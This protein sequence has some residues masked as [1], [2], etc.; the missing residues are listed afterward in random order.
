MFRGR[1]AA[2]FLVAGVIASDAGTLHVLRTTPASPADP[3]DVVT[4]T[5]DRP[6]A[7][8]LDETVDPNA[9]F[10]IAPEVAGTVEWR[11]PVTLRFTP[12]E[13]LT[14]GATYVVTVRSS[15]TAMDGSRLD[16]PFQYSFTVSPPRILDGT[17]AGPR[18]RPRYLDTVP[19]FSILLSAEPDVAELARHATIRLGATCG[20]GSVAL[21]P[22]GTPARRVDPDDDPY[23]F[24]YAGIR[25]WPAPDSTKDLRRVVDLVAAAP[26]PPDC[27]DTLLLPNVSTATQPSLRWPF[28]TRG[29]LRVSG[30]SCPGRACPTGPLRLQLSTPVLGA[31]L[32][33]H[34]R[35]GP[36]VPF[37][38]G[39]TSRASAVWP[40]LATLEPHHT[41]SVLVDGGLVD[42]FGQ[43]LGTPVFRSW[44]TSGYAPAV[45]YEYGSM[46]VEREG[47]GTLAVQHVNADTLVVSR[48]AV[49]DSL[50]PAFLSQRWGWGAPWSEARSLIREDTV[51]VPGAEDQRM[52]S[53]IRPEGGQ[54]S[55]APAATLWALQ[56]SSPSLDSLQRM[57]R[58]IALVQ[59]TD[60]A[61]TA[62][63]GVD[64]AAVWVTG[65][66]DGAARPGVTVVLHDYKGRPLA[67]GRTDESG[68]ATLHDF[69]TWDD[70]CQGWQCNSFEGYVSASLG[71]D[72]AVVPI[73]AYDPDLSP[74][75]FN[76]YSAWGERRA[77]VAAAV[78]TERGI[79]RPGERVFVKAIL[80]RGPLG[81]LVA[82]RGDSIRW[83]FHD[84]EQAV[85]FDTVTTLSAFGTSE[86]HVRLA[87]DLPLGTYRVEVQAQVA[88]SWQSVASDYYR[89]AEYRP[90]EFLVDVTGEQGA[91]FAGDSA[92]FHVSARYLFGAPMGH[93]P[94]S[95][96][97]RSQSVSPW[98][99]SIPGAED[100]QIGVAW[101]WWQDQSAPGVRVTESGVDSLDATGAWDAHRV[102]PRTADGRPTRVTFVATV[103]DA[104]RQIG[105]S[106]A[107]VLVHPA[108]FYIGARSRGAS[109]F[110]RAGD[111]VGI[112]VIAVTPDG[113]KLSGVP[114]EGTVVRREWHSTRLLRD[115]NVRET[116]SWV[117]D[118]V[119]TCSLRSA[120]EPV[121]C[122]FTPPEGGSYTVYFTAK[123]DAGRDVRTSLQRWASGKGWVPWNDES[124][125]K[126]DVIPDR[127][128]YSV[129]DTATV[130]FASPITDA[131]AWITVE[132]ERVLEQRRL[133][134][135]SGATTLK[136]PITE[137]YAPNV[138]VSIVVVR[139]RSAPP[140][141]LDDPGRPTLR[142]GYTQLRITPEVKRLTVDV[143]PL[144]PEYRPGDSASFALTV[145]DHGGVGRR[146]EVALWAVDE[147]VLALTGY[148]TPDPI[149]LLYPARGLGMRLA[150][151][152]VSVAPQVPEGQKGFRSPGG[153][154]G[155]DE[156]G[157]LRSRF[158]TTAFFLGSVVTDSTGRAT[159]G[160][161]LPD[162]LT[163]F[164]VMAVAVTE[165]DRY[166]SGSSEFLV[167]RPLL[168]RPALPRFVREGDRFSA[169]V[170]VNSRMG[171]TPEVD[172]RARTRGI[173]L[174][175]DDHE[176]QRLAAG[177]G[178]DVR[179]DFEAQAGDSAHFRFDASSGKEADAVAVAVPIRPN[180]YPLSNTV[181]GVVRD[182]ATAAFD[183]QDDVDPKRSRVEIRVGS[184]VLTAVQAAR[185][186]LRLY[187]YQCTEQV[188][189]AALPLV[190]LLRAQALYPD[191]R[192]APAD[193][194]RQV[195]RAVRVLASRQRADGGIGYWSYTDWTSP[196]LSAYAGR[197]LLE[198][199]EAGVAVPDTVLSSLRGYMSRALHD[200]GRIV[201]R[202]AVADFWFGDPGAVLAEQVAAVDFLSRAGQPDIPVENTLVGQAQ[203]LRWEDRVLLGEVLA[204]RGQT[205]VARLLVT[206]AA[207]QVRVEG[208][209]AV[210]PDSAGLRL[211]FMS[212]GRAAAR[213]LDA[214]LA[215]DPQSPLLGPLVETLVDQ[216]RVDLAR[217]R[218]WF[219]NTQDYGSTVLALVHF[220][221]LRRGEPP[222]TVRVRVGDRTLLVSDGATHESRD[223]TLSLE[224]LVQR[225][226][227]GE[228]PRTTLSVEANGGAPA[229]F[230]ITVREAPEGVQPT[231]VER[232]IQVDR[233]Y[234]S[235]TTGKPI[236]TAQ[237]GDVV[238]VR[239]R[240]RVPSIRTFVVLADP[241][242]AG[243][244]PV[245]LSLR[246]LSAFGATVP[247]PAE[248]EQ[249]TGWY[250]GSWDSGVW[251]VFDH[252]ELRDDRVVYSSTVLWPGTYTATY[253]ARA[254]ATGTFYYPPAHA[255][256]MYN[257]GVNGR[258]GGGKFTVTVP[259]R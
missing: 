75:H 109:Y 211:Y 105:S 166:G 21:R 62:R 41:Y 202:S 222:T 259:G 36:N 224:G 103:T 69:R 139:G 6:V 58:P 256:E 121:S 55:G 155:A 150:S 217:S 238:R 76:V 59:V 198:A 210:L 151:N 7:G 246:T 160:A 31:E 239:L 80:R 28:W 240:V 212:R 223:T 42:V 248:M 78:F 154:G 127:D 102:L 18:V 20:G 24:R 57:N 83:L 137:A 119:A 125:F 227:D 131:E 233:W 190:A 116:G 27:S 1:V 177:R 176:R 252:K 50:E 52:F 34:V 71:D 250:Y 237:E 148:R 172:V 184:S 29:P 32:L 93:A 22:A 136:F 39:D 242:P 70:P 12:S 229:Y 124:K 82:P 68:L 245:D 173:Q 3:Y 231:P 194:R 214:L 167:T 61:V 220:E 195:E 107:S 180:Y 13:P 74:W 141:P 157:I 81:K 226:R 182:T 138:F 89:V 179:F 4:V 205:A 85:L 114:V 230:S 158:Q 64:E 60:L 159:V 247:P 56:V 178:A 100:Y 236:V 209:K 104:N 188:S 77:P 152:L 221:R 228:P 63:V 15:F 108:A 44:T 253:L 84:R 164:R 225:G 193:A 14:P 128:R 169:G 129:G 135:T 17:P 72:R 88:G 122:D 216:G 25:R 189:S 54:G 163:T 43:R 197:V 90:P 143:K 145:K 46:L 174:R 191:E 99:V 106:S 199:R 53:G 118:T 206:G 26:L 8:G 91:K 134:I 97:V 123:D 111:S 66:D 87:Q 110:W 49:P 140:G 10:A 258:T 208:R 37:T 192:I 47:L 170:V 65:V 16:A 235:V 257:P 23:S 86:E 115:G 94:V 133:H 19:V 38:V 92:A 33:R 183:L 249:R 45:N 51:V 200:R 207:S 95:W 181:S 241:L 168:A 35:L 9:V 67:T 244:E 144:Q 149:D 161:K 79:Y 5:F 147:G 234:E 187:P 219:W 48:I 186:R 204:R 2:A 251:S 153:G 156:T 132:R 171:G 232:G 213:L 185:D 30:L 165:G 112:D 126:M 201:A 98:A 142:V 243:L 255:E 203:R 120:A 40:L 215:V 218:Y 196:W 11:D 117:P 130:F 254:T 146:S 162:N 96:S 113:T 101:S 73:S 175:G